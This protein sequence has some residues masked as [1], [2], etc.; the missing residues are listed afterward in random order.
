MRMIKCM[1]CGFYVR[2]GECR[3]IPCT[4]CG[5]QIHCVCRPDEYMPFS[6]GEEHETIDLERM[7]RIRLAIADGA[8]HDTIID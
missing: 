1:M 7:V 6:D 5:H 4:D 8:D 3:C 2:V